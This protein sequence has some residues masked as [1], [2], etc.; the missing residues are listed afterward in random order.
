MLIAEQNVFSGLKGQSGISRLA[1]MHIAELFEALELLF[2][3][4][5]AACIHWKIRHGKV[6]LDEQKF[7]ILVGGDVLYLEL[8]FAGFD[9]I[10]A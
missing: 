7:V 4:A 9:V 8:N 10:S 6:R 1:W 5:R 2:I 3:D